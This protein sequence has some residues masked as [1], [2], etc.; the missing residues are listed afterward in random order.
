MANGPSISTEDCGSEI[1]R[2]HSTAR[3]DVAPPRTLGAQVSGTDPDRQIRWAAIHW[4]RELH[5]R[6]GTLEWS[7]IR[8]GFR[9]RGETIRLATKARGILMPKQMEAPLSIEAGIPRSER[10]HP[11]RRPG[12]THQTVFAT[13]DHIENP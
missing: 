4:V 9:F 3:Y 1:L 7:Q 5:K 8:D 6:Y 13:Q 2:R 10:A 11:L 12:G